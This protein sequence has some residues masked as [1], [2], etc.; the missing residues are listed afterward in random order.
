[1]EV[2]GHERRDA[3]RGD[4]DGDDAQRLLGRRGDGGVVG[5]DG[6]D[7]P[8]GQDDGEGGERAVADGGAQRERAGP[9]HAV[10]V[11]AAGV[12]ADDGLQSL[13]DAH[14]G[15]GEEDLDAGADG[16]GGQGGRAGGGRGEDVV[17]QDG[18]QGRAEAREERGCADPDQGPHGGAV[19]SQ[20]VNGD[21]VG[22][23][24]LDEEEPQA[25]DG[26]DALPAD[27]A[28]G[29]AA[30]AHAEAED[31]Q[32]VEGDLDQHGNQPDH[33]GV[34]QAALGA[35]EAGE[36][37]RHQ[38]TAQQ[39]DRVLAGQAPGGRFGAEHGEQRFEGEQPGDGDGGGGRPEE[40]ERV[41][42]GAR[43][44]GGV[45]RAEPARDQRGAAGADGAR[46]GA[47]QQ[48]DGRGEVDGGHGVGADAAGDE[49]GVG[50]GVDAVGADREGGL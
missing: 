7:R 19:R 31:E 37:R 23:I 10:A 4:A 32:R 41:A 20:I 35:D 6:D 46:H 40:G 12:V 18:E 34:P 2:G 29:G 39:H 9:I 17:H 1:M 25:H 11:P 42:D 43:R 45:A 3:G 27:G 50:Q 47:E 33:G 13:A 36:A 28:E 48:Q 26:G 38:R 21:A 49:R 30:H 8:G 5:E 44:T 24:A 22:T 14:L 15:H 16:V